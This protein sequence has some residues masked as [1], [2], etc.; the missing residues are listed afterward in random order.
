M[1]NSVAM[2]PIVM[3]EPRFWYHDVFNDLLC[4][5]RC[6]KQSCCYDRLEFQCFVHLDSYFLE[7]SLFY[8]LIK[9]DMIMNHY[10]VVYNAVT[11]SL[12]LVVFSLVFPTLNRSD[13][14]LVAASLSCT[15]LIVRRLVTASIVYINPLQT[16]LHYHLS[17]FCLVSSFRTFTVCKLFSKLGTTAFISQSDFSSPILDS[18]VSDQTKSILIKKNLLFYLINIKFTPFQ[19]ILMAQCD[20]VVKVASSSALPSTKQN[21]ART[22]PDFS[23]AKSYSQLIQSLQSQYDP[24]LIAEF[25]P[26]EEIARVI[27]S[28][29]KNKNVPTELSLELS[30]D[31]KTILVNGQKET[32]LRFDNQNKDKNR[33]EPEQ[34]RVKQKQYLNHLRQIKTTVDEN[35][36]VETFRFFLSDNQWIMGRHIDLAFDSIQNHS[37]NTCLSIANNWRVE[38]IIRNK[39]LMQESPEIDKIFVDNVNNMHWILLTNINPLDAEYKQRLEWFVYDSL[40]RLSWEFFLI[41]CISS[42]EKDACFSCERCKNCICGN[43]LPKSFKQNYS[44]YC[45]KILFLTIVK[46]EISFINSNVE[47]L[48]KDLKLQF[49][50]EN[51]LT[52]SVK[53]CLKNINDNNDMSLT[54]TLNFT[55][56]TIVTIRISRKRK[57]ICTSCSFL[58]EKALKKDLD[59]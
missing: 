28:K 25:F 30:D 5:S 11:F 31:Q 38:E 41:G 33:F 29:N 9:K 57:I 53:L 12:S 52:D 27:C 24:K 14:R 4:F 16:N 40:N 15:T 36:Q 51:G 1:L 23:S 26:R 48:K 8:T 47:A 49:K 6:S 44:F 10:T 50:Q 37:R 7:L 18:R 45:P 22:N 54:W 20:F 17:S 39:F 58:V 13:R 3:F 46:S 43:C 21:E 19:P 32:F 59:E 2:T 35:V 42:S 34:L 56:S 55:F